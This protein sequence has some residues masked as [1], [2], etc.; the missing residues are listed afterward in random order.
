MTK[1]INKILNYFIYFIGR[2]RAVFW[3]LLLKKIGHRVDIMRGVIIMSPQN[4]E[5]GH[6]V[7][8]NEYSRIGG[9]RGVTIGN[10]VQLS[11]NVTIISENHEYKNHSLPI[12]S[13]GYFGG[14][15]TIGDDVWIG[16][17]AVILPNVHIGPGAI[18]GANAV[19]TKDVQPYAIVGGVPARFIKYRFSKRKLDKLPKT[20]L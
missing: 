19:V 18:V 17:N 10:Y 16:S 6:D 3:G 14:P 2:A 9:Q 1:A 15:V 12:K 4:V 20:F 13:Q 7:L 8:L 11:Y 5:I